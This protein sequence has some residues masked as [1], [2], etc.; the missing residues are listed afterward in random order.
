AGAVGAGVSR[1]PAVSRLGAGGGPLRLGG[2]GFGGGAVVTLAGAGVG[3][4]YVHDTTLILDAPAPAGP[5]AVEVANPDGCHASGTVAV[6]HAAVLGVV[7]PVL[8]AGRAV[9]ATAPMTGLHP[10]AVSGG[11]AATPVQR[12]PGRASLYQVAI[13]AEAA[14]LV[15]VVGEEPGCNAQLVVPVAAPTLALAR[16]APRWLRTGRFVAVALWGDGLAGA[17]T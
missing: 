2:A 3:A 11:G 6:G 16:V 1:G 8:P 4:T 12:I 9:T 14:G 5:V 10:D 7:P 13:P 15:A 17:P